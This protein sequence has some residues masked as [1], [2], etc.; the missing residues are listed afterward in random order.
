MMH[1][2]LEDDLPSGAHYSMRSV[3]VLCSEDLDIDRGE[4][5]AD[6]LRGLAVWVRSVPTDPLRLLVA[7]RDAC[8]TIGQRVRVGLPD[9]E[10]LEG[11]A[12]DLDRQGR[13]VVDT[14]DAGPVAVMA[15][16]L[17]VQLPGCS[18]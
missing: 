5:L 7:Y 14:A 8:A 1:P 18:G 4:V 16:S 13:L 17:T 3:G 10:V 2:D 11:R 15:P 9:G 6:L 12:T